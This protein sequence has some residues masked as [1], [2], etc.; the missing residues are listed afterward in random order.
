MG[1]IR[2]MSTG[3]LRIL[4][5]DHVIGRAPAPKCSLA[6]NEP[7]VSGVQAEIRWTGQTWELKDRGSRNGTYLDGRRLDPGVAYPIDAG[8]R[9]SFGRPGRDW[10]LIDQSAP[11]AMAVPLDGG[12]P[13]TLDGEFIPLPS[14]DDPRATIY[15]AIDGSWVLE[16]PGEPLAPLAHMQTFEAVGRLWRFCRADMSPSTLAASGVSGSLGFQVRDAYL[17]FSVSQ[18]EEYVHLRM[19]CGDKD[20]DLGARQHNYLLLTLGRHRLAE[21][22]EGLPEASCGWIDQ[23]D[24][25]HDPSMAPPLL[26]CHVFR[27]R[28]QFAKVGVVDAADI[29]ERRPRPWQ[30]RVGTGRISIATL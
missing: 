7:Y 14:S 4:E 21:A 15:Q 6:L 29:V 20:F 26:N 1:V 13:V 28:Q 16:S 2:E 22:T 30:L 17:F 12:E 9:I 25:S 11:V 8:A 10:E 27:I 24:L 18:D 5:P 23:E 3:Q 19:T